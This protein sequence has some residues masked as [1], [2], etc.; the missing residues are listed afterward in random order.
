[1]YSYDQEV[2][3]RKIA[4]TKKSAFDCQRSRCFVVGFWEEHWNPGKVRIE[5]KKT[6]DFEMLSIAS[7]SGQLEGSGCSLVLKP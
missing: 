1:M 7:Q 3:Q 5:S 4:M 2:S 6:L